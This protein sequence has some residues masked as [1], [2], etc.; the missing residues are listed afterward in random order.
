MFFYVY[1]NKQG[2]MRT[3]SAHLAPPKSVRLI[4]IM[5]SVNMLLMSCIYV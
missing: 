3:C 4:Q 1:D 2:H 5:T